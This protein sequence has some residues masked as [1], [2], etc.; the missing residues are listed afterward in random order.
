MH[1]LKFLSYAM[2]QNDVS[3]L[4]SNVEGN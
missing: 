3:S 1:T 4:R 2:P